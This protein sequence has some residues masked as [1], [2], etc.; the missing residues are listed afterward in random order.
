[1]SVSFKLYRQLDLMD[2]GA[3]CLMMICHHFGKHFSLEKMR[4]LCDKGQQGVT[5]LGINNAA[6][7]VGLKTL[8]VRMTVAHFMQETLLPCIV[9][10]QG[11]H[12][13]VV[14][15]I[16]NGYVYIAD[17]AGAK[18]KLTASQF[19]REWTGNEDTGIALFL[20]PTDK[21]YQEADDSTQTNNGLSQL[22]SHLFRFKNFMVQ[23]GIGAVLGSMLNLIVPFLTQALVDH[24]I[25]NNDINF[26]YAVLV[27]QVILFVSKLA[28][29][30]I[31]GWILVHMGTRVN[32][33]VI[34]EFLMKLMRLP[35]SYFSS[36]NLGDILQRISDH[37]KIEEFLTSHSITL[38]FSMIN[39]IVFSAI[40]MTYNTTIF[41]IFFIGSVI[42]IIWVTLFLKRRRAL[43]NQQFAQMSANQ[44]AVVQLVNGMP[45]IKMN[46]SDSRFRWA[47]ERIQGRLF[48]VRVKALALEQYQQAGTQ[49]LNE[50]KNILIT[51][52]AA[53]AVIDGDMTLGMMMAVIY[54]LGQ[55][56]APIEQF[57]QFVRQ[58]QD[59]KI[60]MERLSE[61]QNLKDEKEEI[62]EAICNLIPPGQITLHDACFKYSIHDEGYTLDHLTCEIPFKKTTAI[63]GTSGSGK[64]TLLKLMLKFYNLNSGKMTVANNDLRILC[65]DT[66]RSKCGVVMQ[67]GYIFDDTV[68]KNVAMGIEQIDAER[69]YQALATAN[70]LEEVDRFPQGIQTKIGQEGL[71]L[72]G[73][74][75]QRILI[76]R[77]VYK[78]PEYLFFDE[79]TS[80][81][82]AN[83]EKAIHANLETFFS[84]KTVVVIAHR[85]STV[86]NADQILVLDKGKIV[87]RGNHLQLTDKKG[88][89]FNLVRNQLELGE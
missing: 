74:Q 2:C 87:E 47:W 25:G 54:I 43:D 61:L 48:K 5:F 51:F 9:H 1:M 63:V 68:A 69:L 52:F 85:L 22:L 45:E 4:R 18:I 23:L 37:N 6:E 21:F 44:N 17:P 38:V 64:T 53:S 26:V 55:M 33:A 49:F 76:A 34:S 84:G 39:L 24:G 86:K 16:K 73:G 35:L 70:I 56:N 13:V 42:S 80:A 75:K 57:L 46:Q 27:A 59:A 7:K 67:D 14:Y 30:F 62:G 50:G 29:E 19:K 60:S 77:A 12:F 89:Y 3:T 15:K 72:S 79:A 41:A 88:Y 78:N 82:D 32:I 36:R 66:W 83:N 10:W 28:N 71:G 31:R 40:M 65:P 20:E 11:N 58:A 81:L 8:P